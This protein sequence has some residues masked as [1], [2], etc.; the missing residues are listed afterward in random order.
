MRKWVIWSLLSVFI[1]FTYM[2]VIFDD[3]SRKREFF[4]YFYWFENFV[5]FFEIFI[6][7]LL[8]FIN[9]MHDDHVLNNVQI[10]SRHAEN[11]FFINI[12]TFTSLDD[13]QT[14]HFSMF[15]LRDCSSSFDELYEKFI[16][17][18]YRLTYLTIHDFQCFE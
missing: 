5:T 14:H 13:H 4:I 11:V 17:N 2:S 8:H 9:S 1:W 15:F 3:R 12:Y 7:D 6:D 10:D 16:F 18:F